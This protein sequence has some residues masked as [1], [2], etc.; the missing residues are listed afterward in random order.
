MAR[1]RVGAVLVLSAV[2]LVSA[3]AAEDPEPA[4]T[5]APSTS[6][7][8]TASPTAPTLERPATEGER[9]QLSN[10]LAEL[11]AAEGWIVRTSLSGDAAVQAG[12]FDVAPGRSSFRGTITVEPR[13]G[14]AST[15]FAIIRARGLTWVKAPADYWMGSGYDSDSARAAAGLFVPFESSAGDALAAQYDPQPL[16]ERIAEVDAVHLAYA[17]PDGFIIEPGLHVAVDGGGIVVR[18]ETQAGAFEIVYAAA[19]SATLVEPPERHDTY[20][21]R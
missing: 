19:E 9:E 21:P 16:F 11:E 10:S 8:S 17:D 7:T 6:P 1:T 4:R 14:E 5:L 13:G 20:L 18:K 12:S 15:T 2:L 3:C